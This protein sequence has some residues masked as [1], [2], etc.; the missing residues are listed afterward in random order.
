ML[1]FVFLMTLENVLTQKGFWKCLPQAVRYS[2]LS[3]FDMDD[4]KVDHF[5]G[6]LG[7]ALG[8]LTIR[9]KNQLPDGM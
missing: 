6:H 1:V 4:F 9:Q 5:L 7:I 3:Y 2:R 8:F